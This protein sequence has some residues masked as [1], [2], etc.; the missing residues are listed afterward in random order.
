VVDKTDIVCVREIQRTL[1]QSVKKLIESK[2]QSL[3]AGYYFDVQDRRILSRPDG[4]TSYIGVM[5]FEGMQDHTADSIKSLEDFDI[6]YCEEAQK[7]SQRSLDLLRPTIRKDGS[8][9]WFAWNPE[10]PTDPVDELLTGENPPPG[11]VVVKANY[12]DNPF[13]PEVLKVELEYDRRRDPDKFAHIWLGEYQRNSESRVFRNWRIEEFEVHADA[14]IRQGADWGFSVDP[15]VLVQCYIVGKTL[16]VPYEAYMIGCEID[17]LPDLFSTV[18]ESASG[19]SRLIQQ[20]RK[21]SASCSGMAS[22]RWA[23]L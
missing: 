9:L 20:G 2:I 8:E 6:A 1:D 13:L 18:P 15:S 23:L 5:I 7:M 12:S 11:T 10:H 17:S 3:N 16:Y 19:G 14:L 4:A 22:Q 21:R